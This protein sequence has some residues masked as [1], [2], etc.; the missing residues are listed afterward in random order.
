VLNNYV[1]NLY[2]NSSSTS[3]STGASLVGIHQASGTGGGIVANNT[4][5]DLINRTTAGNI[6][7]G[8]TS[9]SA[10]AVLTGNTVRNLTTNTTSTGTSTGAS[11]V[12][13]FVSSSQTQTTTNN[14]IRNLV[15]LGSASTQTIGIQSQ[16]S[17]LNLVRGNSISQLISNTTNSNTSTSSGIV[18]IN[19]TSSQLNQTVDS[20]SIIDLVSTNNGAAVNPSIT[21]IAFSGSSTVIGNNS[22]VTRN[23]I[24]GLTHTYPSAPTPTGAIQHGI[25]ISNGTVT[26]ANNLI[27]LGRDSAGVVLARPGQY[28]GIISTASSNQVRIYHNNVLIDFAPDYGA[29]GTPNPST[30]CLEFTGNAFAPGFIDVRN[31]IFANTSVNAGTSTLNHYNEMYSTSNLLLSTNTNIL[32]NSGSSNSF[33]ARWSATNY[34]TLNAFRAASTLA[35]ASGVANPGF[36]APLA[37]S[38]SVNIQ[39]SSP[40]PVEGMGDT[41]LISF[42]SNDVNGLNRSAFGPVDIGASAGNY[43]LSTDSIAPLIYYT[44][45]TN[46]SSPAART[47]TATLYDGTGFPIDTAFGPRVYY[48]N[49]TQLTWVNTPGTFVSGSIRNRVYSFTIDHALLGGLLPGDVVQYYVLAADTGTG[50]INSNPAYAIATNTGNVTT[51]PAQTNSYLFNDPVP[52]VVYLGTGAGT[53]AFTSLTGTGG[54]FS[55]INNSALP[56]NTLVL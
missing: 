26:V 21:G 38:A 20:N 13:I 17:A 54:L 2:T 10:T 46:T 44:A 39:V 36:V 12:G 25:N 45:L 23:R 41:T 40:T 5:S 32:F 11:L 51:H 16:V 22:A 47:F 29:G 55:T 9:L 28:R 53:P 35:G 33:V 19:I 3:T 14:T 50:N 31:N 18:G 1:G 34:A 37:N 7:Y 27:R 6:T 42:V 30:G 24:W 8:I 49:S 43:T 52:T 15:S 48:K 56:G 4:V